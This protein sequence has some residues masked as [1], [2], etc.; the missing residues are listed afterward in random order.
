MTYIKVYFN[1]KPNY[2]ELEVKL[3]NIL[4]SSLNS[5]TKWE[6]LYTD[7]SSLEG[8]SEKSK[9]KYTKAELC[10]MEIKMM[11]V[12]PRL[13]INV[14]KH[15]NHLLKSPFCVHPK[16]GLISVPL[17]ENDIL[18]FDITKVPNVIETVEDFKEGR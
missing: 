17:T 7:V 15:I 4:A 11:L 5:A 9:F 13:D 1:H 6:R 12:Y 16:T 10:L 2:Q 18:R 14:T 8:S 3:R